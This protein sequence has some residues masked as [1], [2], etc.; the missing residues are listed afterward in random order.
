MTIQRVYKSDKSEILGVLEHLYQNPAFVLQYANIFSK[1]IDLYRCY[2]IGFSDC[3][4]LAESIYQET[5][6][7]TFDKK[8]AQAEHVK[9]VE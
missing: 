7:Y 1:A 3:L 6:L 4:I 8:L 9:A 2:K 5:T